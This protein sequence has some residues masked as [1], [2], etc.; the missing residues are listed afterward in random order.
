MDARAG[1]A[2]GFENDGAQAADGGDAGAD[3]SREARTDNDEIGFTQ[4]SLTRGDWRDPDRGHLV[5]ALAQHLEAEAVEGEGLAGIGD[6]ARLMNDEAGERRRLVIRKLPVERA[7]EVA[8]R[9]RAVDDHRAILRLRMRGRF[10]VMLIGNLADDLL[11][12]VL[13]R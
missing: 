8:D 10:G 1:I 2:L 9:R 11:E 3:E 12:H 6:H 5:A 4:R 13:E 7:V